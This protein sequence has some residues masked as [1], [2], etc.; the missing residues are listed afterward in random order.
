MYDK[1]ILVT[2]VL[3]HT[4]TWL[5]NNFYDKSLGLVLVGEEGEGVRYRM[6]F[7]L[8]VLLSTATHLSH[9]LPSSYSL[10]PSLTPCPYP[11]TPSLPFAQPL[12][13]P[14][15]PCPLTILTL[16]FLTFSSFFLSQHMY[17]F[18]YGCKWFLIL[19]EAQQNGKQAW[20]TRR[21][22]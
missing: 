9:S 14:L 11:P 13:L 19:N 5:P 18:M 12:P 21:E 1:I 20:R 2:G 10:P 16:C 22:C 6:C 17:V 8:E 7:A 15:P 4:H 3:I